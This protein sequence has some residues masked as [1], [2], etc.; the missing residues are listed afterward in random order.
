MRNKL[1]AFLL[2]AAVV[3]GALGTLNVRAQDTT[4]LIWA[5]DTRAPI[6]EALGAK[7][8]EEFGVNV[9]VQ[10]LGFGD[11]RSQVKTASPAGEGPDIFVAPTTGS[12]N[13]RRTV[14]LSR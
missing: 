8:K 11:I 6:L 12:A 3:F 9:K 5:D 1:V 13:S 14:C 7:F 2:I 4:L 10:Q